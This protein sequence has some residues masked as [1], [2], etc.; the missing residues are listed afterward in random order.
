M[1]AA[2]KEYEY[3][4]S[5]IEPHDPVVLGENHVAICS[6]TNFII[7]SCDVGTYN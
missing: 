5:A 2:L 7:H 4:Y 6:Y 1:L 3:E